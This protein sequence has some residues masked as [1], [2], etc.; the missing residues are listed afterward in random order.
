MICKH[1]GAEITD[2]SAFCVKCGKPVET[3][4]TAEKNVSE[5]L[6]AVKEA[7]HEQASSSS[8]PTEKA[9][10]LLSPIITLIVSAAGWLYV[11]FSNSLEGLSA[12]FTSSQ[13]MQNSL[14]DSYNYFGNNSGSEEMVG[15]IVFLVIL[16][17]FTLLGIV[18]LIV[19]IKR[20]I[21][22]FSPRK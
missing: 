9:K 12:W 22:K 21:R 5:A 7:S 15:G 4:A 6:T 13:E 16:L 10:G 17:L 18:G 3:L 11:L 1:C 19:F 20:L 14:S 2:G 8:A